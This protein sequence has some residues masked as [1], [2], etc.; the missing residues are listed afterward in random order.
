MIEFMAPHDS[1]RAKLVEADHLAS[2]IA[3]ADL[4][5]ETKRALVFRCLTSS[6]EGFPADLCSSSRRFIDCVDVEDIISESGSG[7]GGSSSSLSGTVL[8]CSLFLFDDKLVFVKRPN[9][10]KSGRALAGLD[11]LDKLTKGGVFP[12]TKKKSA[13]TFRGVVDVTEV[14]AADIEGS[15]EY[16]AVKGS[17]SYLILSHSDIHI[18][19]ENP[20]RDQGDRWSARPFRALSV[21]RPPMPAG[22]D[23][24]QTEADKQRFLESLW[25]V[26]ATYRSNSRL[27]VVRC[28]KEMEVDSRPG[29]TVLART[30]FNIYQR[31]AFLQEPKKVSRSFYMYTVC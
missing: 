1:Q 14:V 9:G 2:Q 4:G 28:A 3:I 26:Q 23:P 22:L 24:K 16:F 8:H 12:P 5:E 31:T 25:H 10:D 19:L 7:G 27:S 6:I 21:V 18:Y 15:G 29:K 11:D 30:Y 13:M 17:P 20:P